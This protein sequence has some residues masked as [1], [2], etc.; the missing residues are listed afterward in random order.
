MH[1][2]AFLHEPLSSYPSVGPRVRI[3]RQANAKIAAEAD[4]EAGLRVYFGGPD[5][6]ARCQRDLLEEHIDAVPA[7]GC[8]DWVTY[9]FRDEALAEALIRAHRR[10]VA[11]HVCLEKNPRHRHANDQVIERLADPRTGIGTGLRAV[12]HALPLHLHTKLYAFS[13]PRP[14]ALVGSFN[15]WGNEPEDPAVISDIG[16][17]DRGHNLLVEL[18]DPDLVAGL[19]SRVRG[20]HRGGGSFTWP[21]RVDD[22]TMKSGDFAGCF[23]PL[24]ARSPLRE[25]LRSLRAADTLRIAASHF[26][27]PFMAR[28]LGKLVDRGVELTLLTGSTK[29]RTPRRIERYLARRG[30]SVRRFCHPAGLPMHSKFVLAVAG[31]ERWASFGSFNMTLTSRWLNHE[32]FMFSS[33]PEL[34]HQLD[35]RWYE[36]LRSESIA[37]RQ[38]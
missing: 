19:V 7:G 27:D 28:Q 1:R 35:R 18:T 29:R 36:I 14:H 2:T 25:R 23:F 38:R 3:A 12:R 8:V 5:Q 37:A 17:Q 4:R 32:L 13:H 9:Y 31:T 30:I 16:D 22:A 6:I 34:W 33:N 24:L 21:T 10:G 26:R 20:L 11:V 15:P